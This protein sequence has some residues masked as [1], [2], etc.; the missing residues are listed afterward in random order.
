M[1]TVFKQHSMPCSIVSDRDPRF[2]GAFWQALFRLLG[3]RLDM[4]TAYHPQTD[5]QT[6]RANRVV[7]EMLRAYVTARQNDWDQ[8]LAMLEFAYNSADQESTKY[9]PFYLNYGQHP[10]T[11]LSMSVPTSDTPRSAADFARRMHDLLQQARTNRQAA[12]EC[13]AHCANRHRRALTVENR[14]L[15]KGSFVRNLLSQ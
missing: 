6:E 9:S 4:S 8:H 2:T 12:Q 10:L 7:T 15:L 5:G 11:P 13:Q 14:V 3:T 1:A